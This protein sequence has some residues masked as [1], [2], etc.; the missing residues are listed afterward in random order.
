MTMSRGLQFEWDDAKAEK[1]LG[2]HG[3]PFA[4]A[5]GVFLDPSVV[6]FDASRAEDGEIRRK[7]VGLID[8]RLYVV[9]HTFRAGVVRLISARRTDEAERKAYGAH[10]S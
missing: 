3:V 2:K 5:I 4:Y 8:G 7:A 9:V 1:N 10:E 6:I